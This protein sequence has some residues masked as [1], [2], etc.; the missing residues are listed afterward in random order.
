MFKKLKEK[1]NA[2]TPKIHK[3]IRNI[4][5]SLSGLSLVVLGVGS[6]PNSVLPAIVFKVASWVALGTVITGTNS[7]LKTTEP[8]NE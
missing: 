7:Q 3:K 5:Y 8:K 6:I 1:W 4:C 2:E